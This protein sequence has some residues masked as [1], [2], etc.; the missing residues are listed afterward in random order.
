MTR[1][2]QIVT[3]TRWQARKKRAFDILVGGIMLLLLAPAMVLI[4]LAILIT[5]GKPVL[6]RHRRYAYDGSPII[7]Y[8]YRT[9]RSDADTLPVAPHSIAG[10]VRITALG[11]VLRS[12]SLDELP[13]LLNVLEGQMSIIGPRP[14]LAL[15]NERYEDT[16]DATLQAKP[17]ITGW[18]QVNGLGG[19]SNAT[20]GLLARYKLDRYYLEHWSIEFD[21]VILFK[22]LQLIATQRAAY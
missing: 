21:L 14:R 10:D 16:S 5:S 9:M 2:K 7:I 4:G 13:Q 17:G 22:T 11:R 15:Y 19:E 1:E 3:L 12:T 20:D 6:I 18:S 8:K